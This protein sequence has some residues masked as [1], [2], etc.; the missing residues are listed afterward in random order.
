MPDPLDGL[1]AAQR[2]A[3]THF[4]GPLLVSGGPGSGKTRV[5]TRRIA[6]LVDRGV[7]AD[8]I[9]ALSFSSA[10]AERVRSQ[11]EA[12]VERPYEELWILGFA[13]LCRRL[14]RDEALEAGLD[15]FFMSVSRA[16]RVA[17]LLERVDDLPLSHHEIRGNPAPLVASLVARIDRLKEA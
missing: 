5:V 4:G 16:D 15:P 2:A 11:V 3:V 13:D 1:S 14:L 8:A 17:L 6:W 12:L 7:P 9:L 10:A